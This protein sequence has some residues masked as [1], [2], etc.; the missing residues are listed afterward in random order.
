MRTVKL[1]VLSLALALGSLIAGCSG[2]SSRGYYDT[3]CVDPFTQLRMP[4]VY[5]LVGNPLYHSAWVYY[6][7]VGYRAPGYGVHVTNYTVNNYHRPSNAVIHTGGV[8]T[9]GGKATR[10]KSG[11]VTVPKVN[12]PKPKIP[13]DKVAPKN[14]PYQAPKQR[15]PAP[16]APAPVRPR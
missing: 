7:P 9:S 11:N 2:G 14:R 4:D 13:N 3:I 1:A 8:P 12:S 6:V 16:R 5:C 15:A 10:F